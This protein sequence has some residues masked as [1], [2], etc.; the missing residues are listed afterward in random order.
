[1]QRDGADDWTRTHDIGSLVQC[2]YIG[3]PVS[4][5]FGPERHQ[6]SLCARRTK[7]GYFVLCQS[8]CHSPYGACMYSTAT[9]GMFR[10]DPHTHTPSPS[11]STALKT[12]TLSMVVVVWACWARCPCASRMTIA[13]TV[14]TKKGDRGLW[15]CSLSLMCV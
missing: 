14:H 3:T 10:E 9:M 15:I 5:Y 13:E 7:Y 12:I 11:I 2:T 6:A 1:M 8:V 4:C